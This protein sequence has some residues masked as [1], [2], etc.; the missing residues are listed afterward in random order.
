[1]SQQDDSPKKTDTPPTATDAND[2]SEPTNKSMDEYPQFDFVEPNPHDCIAVPCYASCYTCQKTQKYGEEVELFVCTCC[3]PLGV[4]AIRSIG[5]VG[6]LLLPCTIVFDVMIVWVLWLFVMM[7]WIPFYFFLC[8][9][10]LCAPSF[11]PFF[12][13]LYV[14]NS[15]FWN[16]CINFRYFCLDINNPIC[17]HEIAGRSRNEMAGRGVPA[18]H[19]DIG[20]RFSFG[21]F[22][23]MTW[24]LF[25][26]TLIALPIICL[27]CFMILAGG[28][29][30]NSC[31][32]TDCSKCKC[33]DD[34]GQTDSLCD[35]CLCWSCIERPEN[36][37]D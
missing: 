13:C 37:F 12:N 17:N 16:C 25:L 3:C 21:F 8:C 9:P 2:V 31:R 10:C 4:F 6:V 26:G 32:G 24:W 28:S 11:D 27:L 35:K 22:F 15:V 34:C 14:Q 33:T 19:L 18:F 36:P 23:L 29:G 7:V 1:M 5:I 20:H 30:G